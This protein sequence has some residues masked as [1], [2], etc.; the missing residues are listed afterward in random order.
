MIDFK[1]YMLPEEKER[2]EL[3]HWSFFLKGD[4]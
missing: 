2:P 1:A 4:F 3:K